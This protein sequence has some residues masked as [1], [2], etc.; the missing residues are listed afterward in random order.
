[1][2]TLG[3]AL[4]MFAI[5]LAVALLITVIAFSNDIGGIQR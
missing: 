2:E 3:K 5:V 4:L 1:M